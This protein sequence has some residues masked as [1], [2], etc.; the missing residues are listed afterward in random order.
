MNLNLMKKEFIIT[1][2][3]CM[4][5][6]LALLANANDKGARAVKLT[7]QEVKV[8]S[9][10]GNNLYLLTFRDNMISYNPTWGYQCNF[11]KDNKLKSPSIDL[12]FGPNG[13]DGFV[14]AKGLN[15]SLISTTYNSHYDSLSNYPNRSSY[16]RMTIINNTETPEKMQDESNWENYDLSTLPHIAIGGLVQLSDSTLLVTG[17]LENDKQHIIHII[18][19]KH[20]KISPLDYSP[21]NAKDI[22]S[23]NNVWNGLCGNGKG[24]YLYYNRENERFAFI[25]SIE[26]N[27]V[28]VIKYLYDALPKTEQKKR[29]TESLNCATND[30]Y[31]SVLLTDSEKDGKRMTRKSKSTSPDIY[32]NTVELYDWDGNRQKILQ[33]DHYGNKIMLS[34][35]GKHLYLLANEIK[36]GG[37]SP[38]TIWVYD[39]SNLD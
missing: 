8:N 20:N 35:D 5:M 18:D 3:A 32:G 34:D 11:L 23:L 4:L 36:Y 12:K 24:H 19:Y 1:L 14:V 9:E 33:L 25:F 22:H 13:L 17:D 7:G 16:Q 30:K 27:K 26:N 29:C 6:P 31:I 2:L 10:N 39:I 38:T 15:N 28:N 37:F 21:K